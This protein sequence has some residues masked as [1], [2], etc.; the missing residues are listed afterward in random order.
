M[1]LLF[2]SG[3]AVLVNIVRPDFFGHGSLFDKLREKLCL[4]FLVIKRC[5]SVM[6]FLLV[7]CFCL[8]P[9][10]CTLRLTAP[11]CTF[12]RPLATLRLNNFEYEW[13]AD[14]FMEILFFKYES[15]IFTNPLLKLTSPT[16]M[17]SSNCTFSLFSDSRATA[18]LS[19]TLLSI[20]SIISEDCDAENDS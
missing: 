2:I 14:A 16:L 7:S 1:F 10:L 3:Y 4:R 18:L 12:I 8:L 17:S 5:G 19:F 15:T 11:G 13:R 6:F 20:A 9:F